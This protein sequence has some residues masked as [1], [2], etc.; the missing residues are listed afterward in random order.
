MTLKNVY[1]T[2][3]DLHK[4]IIKNSTSYMNVKNQKM[5]IDYQKYNQHNL[6]LIKKT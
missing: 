3:I 2:F 6:N 1:P 5:Q 4:K